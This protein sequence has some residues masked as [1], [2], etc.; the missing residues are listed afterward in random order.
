MNTVYILVSV[1]GYG[2]NGLVALDTDHTQSEWDALDDDSREDV[3]REVY[4]ENITWGW[5]VATPDEIKQW[6]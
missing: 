3:A 4:A 5:S 6:G 2:I 1:E